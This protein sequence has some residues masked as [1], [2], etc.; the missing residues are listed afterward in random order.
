MESIDFN[1]CRDCPNILLNGGV[2]I[3]AETH[4]IQREVYFMFAEMELNY[5]DIFENDHRIG[6]GVTTGILVNITK[7]W[8]ILA[9]GSYSGYLLGDRSEDIKI[10]LKQRFTLQKNLA[11]KLELNREQKKTEVV[12]NLNVYF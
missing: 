8:K 7:N 3:A 1:D 10:S 11:L 5:G 2:G 6:P 12:F 4:W 9:S